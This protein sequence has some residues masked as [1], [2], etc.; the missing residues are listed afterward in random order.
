MS[1]RVA[2]FDIDKTILSINSAKLWV[3][4]ELE[5][6]TMSRTEA[7]K[8]MLWMG[9]YG[10]GATRIERAIHAVV[11]GLQGR[12]EA[13]VIEDVANFYEE[14][15]ASAI[16]P[17]AREAVAWH[18]ERGDAV[19]LL[20]SSSNYIAELV[21]EELGCDAYASNRF[22]VDASGCY[23]GHAQEPLC[24]GAGKVHYA[25][26]IASSFDSSLGASYFYTDSYS[27]LPLLKLVRH[28]RVVHPD[29]RLR[30]E[31]LWQRWPILDWDEEGGA[32][33]AE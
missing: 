2:F 32:S 24:F 12:A 4:Y 6:G 29:P 31:A 23:T 30:R 18:R 8:G 16:R 20:T 1:M 3:R 27:D 33:I 26:E 22:L 14:F 25:R 17:G 19:V 21:Q 13:P 11:A 7:L 9:L 15:V 28:P 5:R 10:L